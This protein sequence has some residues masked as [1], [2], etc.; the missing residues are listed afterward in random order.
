MRQAPRKTSS[1]KPPTKPRLANDHQTNKEKDPDPPQPSES[2]TD[3]DSKLHVA[4]QL[5]DSP[6]ESTTERHS[7]PVHRDIERVTDRWTQ[8][9]TLG[10]TLVSQSFYEQSASQSDPWTTIS[11]VEMFPELQ[12]HQQQEQQQPMHYE[13]DPT[14]RYSSFDGSVI[15]FGPPVTTSPMVRQEHTPVSFSST[16]NAPDAMNPGWN[17]DFIS[18]ASS[19]MSLQPSPVHHGLPVH[20]PVPE[21][22]HMV[23]NAQWDQTPQWGPTPAAYPTPHHFHPS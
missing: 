12:Q 16:S 15:G 9:L 14:S 10:P 5:D 22:S 13:Q 8:S 6:Y 1:A 21:Q 17:Q 18:S 23:F 19:A 3:N 2:C 4:L 7:A 20:L 11:N